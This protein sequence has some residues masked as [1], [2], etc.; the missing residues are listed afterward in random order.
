M[1]SLVDD[2]ELE[3]GIGPELAVFRPLRDVEL[4]R[5]AGIGGTRI[6]QGLIYGADRPDDLLL[7]RASEIVGAFH[8][9][10]D[11]MVPFSHRGV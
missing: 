5:C 6:E 10:V 4:V 11:R 7:E 3:G 1:A 9:V 2:G 8:G